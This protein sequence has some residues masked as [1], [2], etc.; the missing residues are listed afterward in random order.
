MKK[1]LLLCWLSVYLVTPAPAQ[2]KSALL[3]SLFSQLHR[4]KNFNGNVLIAEKGVPIF[5]KSYGKADEQSDRML[6]PKSAF[7][8]ASLSKQ[9]TAL[10]IVLLQKQGK[11]AYDDPMAKYLPELAHYDKITLRHLLHHTSGLPNY[12]DYFIAHWDK[13]KFATNEDVIKAFAQVQPGVLFQPNEKFNYSNT[14]YVL[15]GSIIERVSGQTYADF[16]DQAIFKPLGMTHTLVYQSRFKPQEVEDYALGYLLDSLGNKVTPD[17][18]GK[19]FFTYFLDGMVGDRGVSSTARD[20]LKWDQALYTDQLIGL[21]DKE[22]LFNGL[23]TQDG[24]ET[25]YGF[26]WMLKQDEQ[27]GKL[28]S[29]SGSWAGYIHYFDR[30]L[31]RGKTIIVLQNLDTWKNRIAIEQVRKILYP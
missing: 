26:G 8:L 16:L 27:Y 28:V 4:Q 12:T 6:N 2:S 21:Q 14:G 19:E 5:E 22:Q 11:L 20:L 18:Y 24:R 17:S 25:G 1:L 29:H 13:S 31:D 23:K 10:A 30:H 3:D 9:F 15:L 7:E